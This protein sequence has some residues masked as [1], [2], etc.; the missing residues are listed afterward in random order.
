MVKVLSVD[1]TLTDFPCNIAAIV[2]RCAP[3]VILVDFVSTVHQCFIDQSV[4][5][6]FPQRSTHTRTFTTHLA[7]RVH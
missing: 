3:L 7:H 5:A 4:S 2:L 6:V 1:S